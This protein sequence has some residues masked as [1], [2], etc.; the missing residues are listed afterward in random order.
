MV[1]QPLAG[2]GSEGI[3]GRLLGLKVLLGVM[4]FPGS[5]SFGGGMV[6]SKRKCL[7]YG[8]IRQWVVNG[9]LAATR[10]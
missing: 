8:C 9:E 10:R 6:L 3:W 7:E 5:S 2:G 1:G 4:G